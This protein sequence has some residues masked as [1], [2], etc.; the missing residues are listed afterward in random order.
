MMH[1]FLS[2]RA[3]HRHFQRNNLLLWNEQ[4]LLA[5]L[6]VSARMHSSIDRSVIPDFQLFIFR[7]SILEPVFKVVENDF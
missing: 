6:D 5:S 3:F 1:H 2:N 7:S 4:N